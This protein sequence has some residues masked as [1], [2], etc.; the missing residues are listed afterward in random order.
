MAVFNAHK[1]I[2]AGAGSEIVVETA[3]FFFFWYFLARFPL[4]FTSHFFWNHL[5]SGNTHLGLFQGEIT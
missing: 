5:S 1:S 4:L 2:A 3:W